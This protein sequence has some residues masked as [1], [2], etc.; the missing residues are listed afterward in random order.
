M[1]TTQWSASLIEAA[2]DEF[3]RLRASAPAGQRAVQGELKRWSPKD[4]MAHLVYWL[5]LYAAKLKALRAGRDPEDVRNYQE[6][7][8]AAWPLRRNWTWDRVEQE[9]LRALQ[10]VAAEWALLSEAEQRQ[11]MRSLIYEL[12]DH[13]HHHFVR[14]YRKFRQ[15]ARGKAMLARTEALLAQRGA[16]KW[17]VTPRRKLKRWALELE[18]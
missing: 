18:A 13:P 6:R 5:D 7:N 17:T 8:D 10:Q 14:L 4:E 11:L 16:S 15:P 3:S 1:S 12:V 2:R 9:W